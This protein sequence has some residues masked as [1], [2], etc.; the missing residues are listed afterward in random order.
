MFKSSHFCL[1]LSLVA[2]TAVAGADPDE[3]AELEAEGQNRSAI[4]LNE[5]EEKR[6]RQISVLDFYVSDKAAQLVLENNGSALDLDNSRLQLGF[7]FTEERDNVFTG[8][9]V[10]DSTPEFISGATLSLG[11]KAYAGLLGIENADVFG[12]A[13]GLEAGYELDIRELPLLL[14][15]SVYYAPDV[16]TFGQ[17]DRILDWQARAGLQ[18]RESVIAYLGVRYLEFDTRPGD[19]KT[20]QQLHAGVRFNFGG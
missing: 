2:S 11:G 16:L 7:L 9:I 3:F 1:L 12:F 13:M 19:R 15:A 20:D 6:S 17:S 18:L 10:L 5:P 14:N 4:S 8:G